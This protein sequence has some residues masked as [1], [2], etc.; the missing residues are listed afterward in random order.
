MR[1]YARKLGFYLVALWAALT[2]NFFIPRL[3]PGN[4]VDTLMA[5]LAQ[6]GG[7]VDAEARRAYALLLGGD[8]EGTLL[9]QYFAYLGNLARGDLGVSVSA[10]PTPVSEVISGALPWTVV[11][12]GVATVLSFLLGIG[13]GAF[14]GWRRGT[15]LDSLVPATTL[16]AAVPYFWLALILV[17]LLASGL[18]WFPLI[19][20]YD[21]VLDTGWNAEFIGSAVYH[22]TLPA[23]T[24][25]LSSIGGWLLGMRNMMVS[26]TAED[27]VLTAQAKGLRGS[28]VMVRYAARNAVLPSFAA[29]AISLGFVVSGSIITE[30]VF[31]YPGI[32]SKLL[33]AV[34]NNDYALM[35]GIFLVITIAVL[36]ANL[37]VDLLYAVVDPRT[38]AQG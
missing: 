5:K 30:Q 17:A 31:S 34:Q 10:F 33:Q 23:L 25:V 19:G 24:I 8:S 4:P 36:G 37:V 7:Q 18:G 16:L 32:G 13:L 20:G 11:L 3:M 9:E 22:G 28:R 15:W 21:V 1:Y 14:V 29:F 35:Q 27:Y 38:R 6:R 12:V 2:L 26:T